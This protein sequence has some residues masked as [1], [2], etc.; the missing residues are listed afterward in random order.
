[1]RLLYIRPFVFTTIFAFVHAERTSLT[2]E[3][4]KPRPREDVPTFIPDIRY[5]EIH[6]PPVHLEDIYVDTGHNLQTNLASQL[7]PWTKSK[8]FQKNG[9]VHPVIFASFD[10]FSAVEWLTFNSTTLDLS[11]QTPFSQASYNVSVTL[12]PMFVNKTEDIT[13]PQVNNTPITFTTATFSIHVLGEGASDADL[14]GWAPYLLVIIS[15]IALISVV[16]VL[17]TCFWQDLCCLW[18][19]RPW[20]TR[21]GEKVEGAEQPEDNIRENLARNLSR[22]RRMLESG[23]IFSG[24]R[25]PDLNQVT[26][27]EIVAGPASVSRRVTLRAKHR[28]FAHDSQVVQTVPSDAAGVQHVNALV[29]SLFAV[30]INL[31]GGSPDE[32]CADVQ[33]SYQVQVA[34]YPPS[35]MHFCPDRLILW[36]TPSEDLS[37]AAVLKFDVSLISNLSHLVFGKLSLSVSAAGPPEELEP[38]FSHIFSGTEKGLWYEHINGIDTLNILSG[39]TYTI[40]YHPRALA[41]QQILPGRYY[42]KCSQTL[43]SWLAFTSNPLEITG[44]T[45]DHKRRDLRDLWVLDRFTERVIAK[46]R[47]TLVVV[48]D[49]A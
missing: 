17:A 27:Y 32:T 31:V 5:T 38:C 35:W 21:E 39:T 9:T 12:A 41:G 6:L 14:K 25:C 48:E 16:G 19:S 44:D 11:G 40:R 2:R 47:V 7:L 24:D 8:S 3:V 4:S 28:Q 42:F 49:W 13:I 26:P 43:P 30:G 46:L 22:R 34:P 45:T 20:N 29:G 33:T 10:P 23:W 18:R 36:G 1:M 15:V 37:P